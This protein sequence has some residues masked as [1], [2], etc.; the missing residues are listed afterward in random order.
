MAVGASLLLVL[1]VSCLAFANSINAARVAENARALHW[2]NAT[3]GT[4]SLARAAVV[5]AI[6]FANW[7]PKAWPSTTMSSMRRIR[8][9]SLTES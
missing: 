5:Q 9:K 6:T 3:L 7:N 2:A 4:S 8:S 1:F